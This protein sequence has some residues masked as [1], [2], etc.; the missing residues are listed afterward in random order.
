MVAPTKIGRAVFAAFLKNSLL[1]MISLF[2]I[3]FSICQIRKNH[4]SETQNV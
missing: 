4:I 3:A 2:F 1:F